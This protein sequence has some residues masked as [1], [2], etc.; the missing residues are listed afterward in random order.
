MLKELEGACVFMRF[1][2]AQ[3]LVDERIR[4]YVVSPCRRS[5]GETQ[6]CSNENYTQ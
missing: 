5:S 4:I 6:Q 2:Q 3:T 1:A